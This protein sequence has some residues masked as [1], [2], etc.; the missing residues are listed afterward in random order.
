MKL[1][2]ETNRKKSATEKA[3]V[4][5]V[6]CVFF[7]ISETNK[8]VARFLRKKGKEKLSL[9]GITTDSTKIKRI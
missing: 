7:E 5:F 8:A 6:F 9:S 2:K 3:V 4:F 1:K